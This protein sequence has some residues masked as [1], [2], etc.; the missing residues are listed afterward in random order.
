MVLFEDVIKQEGLELVFVGLHLDLV[1][2]ASNRESSM[3]TGYDCRLNELLFYHHVFLLELHLLL[4][5][6]LV[7]V[8]KVNFIFIRNLKVL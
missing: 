4:V 3:G 2:V 1:F 5:F 7:E 8:V 6:S